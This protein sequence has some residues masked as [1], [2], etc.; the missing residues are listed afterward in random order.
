MT[1][2]QTATPPVQDVDDA[3]PLGPIVQLWIKPVRGSYDRTAKTRDKPLAELTV[4]E[5]MDWA[6]ILTYAMLTGYVI[7]KAVGNLAAVAIGGPKRA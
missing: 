2:V 6:V 3:G 7:G 5:V 1:A 4:P